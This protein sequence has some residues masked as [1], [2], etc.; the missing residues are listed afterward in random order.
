[1]LLTP[2][3][4]IFQRKPKHI[5]TF[6]VIVPHWHNTHS[7]NPS[8][9]KTNTYRF[10]IFNIMAADDLATQGARASA[11][12]IFTMLNLINSVPSSVNIYTVYFAVLKILASTSFPM[13]AT[14]WVPA[15]P[16]PA[17]TVV[18]GRFTTVPNQPVLGTI[19]TPWALIMSTS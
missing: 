8:S 15:T 17:L 19:P 14:C 18:W 4:K 13:V 2:T 9:C 5:Y 1:M 11:T 3:C 7:W 12:I 16:F 10:Y 6:Y